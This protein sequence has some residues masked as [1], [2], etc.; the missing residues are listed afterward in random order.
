MNNKIYKILNLSKN[1][2]EILKIIERNHKEQHHLV[3][4][5]LGIKILMKKNI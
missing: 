3:H 5:M 4:C 2:L 1:L